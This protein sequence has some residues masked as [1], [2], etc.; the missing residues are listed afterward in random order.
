MDARIIGSASELGDF[1]T[2]T[3]YGHKLSREWSK[4]EPDAGVLAKLQGNR[5]VELR[6]KRKASD[7]PP[8]DTVPE[9]KARLA[10]LGVE[11]DPKA[12]KGD[13]EALLEQAEAAKAA[14]EGESDDEADEDETGEDD[15]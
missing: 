13:L 8:T 12:K 6:D 1:H 5:F 2:L 10:D 11:F 15:A 9:I 4:V 3:F 14:A 7:E